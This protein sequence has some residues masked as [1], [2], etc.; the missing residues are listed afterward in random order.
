MTVRLLVTGSRTIE[1]PRVVRYVLDQTLLDLGGR[2][3]ILD[4]IHGGAPGVD[5]LAGV[6]AGYYRI[7]VRVV[8]PDYT[9]PIPPAQA[10]A[11]R[12]RLMVDAYATHVV[13]IWDGTSKGTALT[14]DHA[15]RRGKLHKCWLAKDVEEELG[16]RYER[17]VA[18]AEMDNVVL[19]D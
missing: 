2:P 7:P 16:L 3:A 9:R 12:D 14:K 17:I 19:E 13:A 6:W 15:A 1:E 11:I 5:R 8:R 18:E 4:L 10:C